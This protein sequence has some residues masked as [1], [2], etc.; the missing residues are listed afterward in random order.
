M[1]I[2]TIFDYNIQ[3]NI[4]K[5]MLNMFVGGII[6]NC[7]THKYKIHII[8]DFVNQ[9]GAMFDKNVVETIKM[10]RYSVDVPPNMKNITNK[11]YN[12][13]NLDF[14]FIFL[15]C[16][17]YVAAD[18]SFLWD[19]R[20]DKPFISTVHQKNIRGMLHNN[21]VLNNNNFMNSGLQI[22]SDTDFLNYEKLFNL[23]AKM[24]FNFPVPGADQA[25]LDTYCKQE[26]GYDYIHPDIG[27]EWNSCAG[28]GVVTIDDYYNFIIN[29][30]ND[31]DSEYPV[32]INHYWN[33]FKPWFIKCPIFD[34]YKEIT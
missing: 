27:S 32:K 12:L 26:L 15:D 23:A 3:N 5:T 6:E 34:F 18:L 31:M 16:D 20:G 13:C 1:N 14:E 25:L 24:N 2:V 21:H 29:Y 4:Y 33:E 30:Q 9:V 10:K 11:L 22:V 7:N 19:R 17:M 8:T 28:Y